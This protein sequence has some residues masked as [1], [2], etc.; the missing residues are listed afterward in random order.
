MRIR[1]RAGNKWIRIQVISFKLLISFNKAEFSIFC[2]IF[3]AHFLLKLN[4][5]FRN[6]EI[7]IILLFSI[8]QTWVLRVNVDPHIFTHINLAEIL[9]GLQVSQ[10]H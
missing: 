10:V 8:V 2:L 6:Q 9:S 7:F 5:P 3:L 1:I 4:E